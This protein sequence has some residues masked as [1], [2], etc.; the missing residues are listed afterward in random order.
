MVCK[1]WHT[2]EREH[3][4]ARQPAPAAR[5]VPPGLVGWS[6]TWSV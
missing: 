6:P 1:R 5:P 4:A 2:L 3:P